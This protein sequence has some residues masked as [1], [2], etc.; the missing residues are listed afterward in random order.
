M[1]AGATVLVP[2]D[3][4]EPSERILSLIDRLPHRDLKVV[5]L[6]VI[7]RAPTS[8]GKGAAF[9]RVFA[10]LEGLERRLRDRG[11]QAVHMATVGDPAAQI[12]D[13]TEVVRPAFVAMATHGRGGLA[14]TLRGSV[15]EAVLE[16]CPVPLLLA[17]PAALPLD[18]A[19]GFARILVPLAVE[20]ASARVLPYVATL[21]AAHQARVVLLHVG[22]AE[23]PA[24]VG[25]ALLAPHRARL[26]EDGVADV[27]VRAVVG[28]PAQAIE[29]EQQRVAADLLV[30]GSHSRRQ[31]ATRW[32]GTVSQAVLR[33]VGCPLLLIRVATP[34]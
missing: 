32:L 5:L 24:S 34:A 27:E 16:R 7:P 10:Y 4:S 30:L 31:G 8:A 26:L 11:V 2:V 15:A 25:E 21:A 23:R 3:G 18:P 28:D 20:P 14:R 1:Q 13:A 22:N 19:S 33:R 9:D 6:Q 12:L 17:N 29:A